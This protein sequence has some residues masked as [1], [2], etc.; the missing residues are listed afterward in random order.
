MR[1]NLI[2]LLAALILSI[3]IAFS[4]YQIGKMHLNG[5]KFQRYVSIIK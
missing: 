4:G 3:G 5:L 2:Y 1:S